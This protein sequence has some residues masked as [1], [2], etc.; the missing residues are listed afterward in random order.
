MELPTAADVHQV[1]W[2][3]KVAPVKRHTV[4]LVSGAG[5]SNRSQ[6]ERRS[7]QHMPCSAHEGQR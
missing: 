3:P 2:R 5:K 1:A 4:T 7:P 6:A